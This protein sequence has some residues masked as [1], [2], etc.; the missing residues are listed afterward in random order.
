MN[1]MVSVTCP[2]CGKVVKDIGR[3]IGLAHSKQVEDMF[4]GSEVELQPELKV[5]NPPVVNT[6]SPP[7]NSIGIRGSVND[8]IKEKLDTMLNIK[9]IEML[10]ANKDVGIKEI[11]AMMQ[12][13]PQQTNIKELIELH[14][15]LYPEKNEAPYI[16]TSN[17]WVNVAQQALPMIKDFASEMISK[18]I[19]QQ[20]KKME[21][22]KNVRLQEGNRRC[23]TENGGV[24][25]N[26]RN[27]TARDRG[28]PTIR[29]KESA[30]NLRCDSSNTTTTK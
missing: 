1:K 27:E 23:E 7:V 17:E 29:T 13:P 10:S 25:Q 14:N 20:N 12:P 15:L 2:V 8:L 21:E 9:I 30:D 16:E 19:E 11:N 26:G 3:H 4:M 22:N 18:R 24:Y 5:N 28:K 6:S